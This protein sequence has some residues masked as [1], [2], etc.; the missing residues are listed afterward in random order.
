MF[1]L[2]FF[3]KVQWLLSVLSNAAGSSL[4]PKRASPSGKGRA[5]SM[6]LYTFSLTLG[7]S[8]SRLDSLNGSSRPT[9]QGTKIA[10]AG[11][12]MSFA[13]GRFKQDMSTLMIYAVTRLGRT[14]PSSTQTFTRRENPAIGGE[15]IPD[16]DTCA[17][18]I[19]RKT[20]VMPMTWLH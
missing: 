15:M 8:Q 13:R 7:S 9:I 14:M 6:R 5:T 19:L 16:R 11:K 12:L 17:K 18:N 3:F 10:E 1:S 20:S 4:S 2:G